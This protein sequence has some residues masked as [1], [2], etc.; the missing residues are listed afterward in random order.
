MG[1]ADGYPGTRCKRAIVFSPHRRR[2]LGLGGA[3]GMRRP[4]A[5]SSLSPGPS[6]G[7]SMRRSSGGMIG[8]T[9]DGSCSDNRPVS[10]LWS[11]LSSGAHSSSG[12]LRSRASHV[13]SS[14]TSLTICTFNL[15]SSHYFLVT[16]QK[17]FTP[18]Y[19]MLFQQYHNLERQEE[20][21]RVLRYLGSK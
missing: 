11:G 20:V 9:M 8:L 14:L 21:H 7:T 12:H 18:S 16:Y 5:A 3:A 2:H 13:P 1:V 10:S 15:I 4:P 19:S 17:Y 6:C